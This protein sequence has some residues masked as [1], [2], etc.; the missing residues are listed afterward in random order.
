[1]TFDFN[2]A[3]QE[4]EEEAGA[5]KWDKARLF[6]E[7]VTFCIR[8]IEETDNPWYDNK[9]TSPLSIFQMQIAFLWQGHRNSIRQSYRVTQDMRL[10]VARHPTPWHNMTFSRYQT[11]QG[12]Y[13]Y[14]LTQVT[15][16][17][18][19]C[20]W[21]RSFK[22]VAPAP[23]RLIAGD[24]VEGSLD[25]SSVTKEEVNSILQ[26]MGFEPVAPEVNVPVSDDTWQ[27]L[28][29]GSLLCKSLGVVII[30][31]EREVL[32]EYAGQQLLVAMRREWASRS[33]SQAKSQL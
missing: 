8:S 6:Y 27:A 33:A 21:E 29:K 22:E 3:K 31:P 1:M 4:A 11:K 5:D 9:E 17:T 18:S 16:D 20:P 23:Q 13:G 28:T 14:N 10:M 15:P 2:K 19:L 32:T 30:P 12:S 24:T 25:F 7:H 26:D